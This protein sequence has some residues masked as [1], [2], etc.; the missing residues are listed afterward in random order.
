MP[1]HLDAAFGLDAR[2]RLDEAGAG[3]GRPIR[4]PS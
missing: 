4:R 2:N 3:S 1:R